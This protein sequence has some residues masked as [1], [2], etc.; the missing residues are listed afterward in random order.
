MI[1]LYR[2][3]LRLYPASF[4]REY[5]DE[6]IALFVERDAAVGAWGRVGLLLEAV[7]EEVPHAVAVHFEVLRQ[8]LRFAARSLTRA[9]AFALTAVLVT[10]IGVGANTAAFSVADFVLLR[11]LPYPEPG[12]LVRLCEGPREGGGWGCMNQLS[13]A[14]Y[15]DFKA[16]S[17]S[18][19]VL[20]A[21]YRNAANLVGGGEPQR[22][23]IAAVTPEVL[24]LLGVSPRF[25]RVFGPDTELEEP[26][27]V[28]SHGLWRSRFGGDPDAVGRTVEL[29]GAPFRVI[30]VMP[31][32]FHF[33]SRDVQVW[34]PLAFTAE[35]YEDRTNTYVEGVGR[36]MAGV[37]FEQARAD[38]AAVAARL[39]EAYP[40]TNEE[41]G[42]SFFRLRDEMS[43]R[44]RVLLL[45]LCGASLC[46]LLLTCANLASLL[47]ARAAGRERELAVRASLGAGRERLVRQ[48][49]T[50][51]FVLTLAGG[52]AGV[53]VAAAAVP[54]LT[55]LVPG[56]LPIAGRPGL[57]LRALGIG[58]AFTLVTG[59][60]IGVV[61]ALRAGG[62]WGWDALREGGRAGGGRKQRL[63]AWLVGLEVAVSVA[64]LISA[65]LL[66]RAV[67]QVQS[68]DPGFEPESVLTLKTALPRPEYD[69]PVRRSTFYDEVLSGVRALPGVESAAYT[70]G[71]PMVMTGGI[72]PATTPGHEDRPDWASLRFITPGYFATL[73]IPMLRGRD[74]EAADTGDRPFVAVVSRSFA[75]RHWP[76]DEPLGQTFDIAF[77]ARTVV[78]VVDD[79]R[80]RGLE[81]PSEPQVYLP[82]PQVP[83]GG[84]INYDPKDLV[85]RSAGDAMG[86]LPRIR[87]IVAAADPDQ[88]ISDVRMLEGVV[89][90]DTAAR[91]AQ[92]N[93]LAALAVIALLLAGVGI[94]GL[95]A[96]TV[97]QRSRE[98]AVRLALGAAPAGV[99]RLVLSDGLKLA[100]FGIVPGVLG[101][102]AAGRAMSSLLFGVEPAD[103]V[104]IAAV[105][106]LA[107]L[108]TVAGSLLPT[109][110]AVRLSP[111]TA[112]KA[113]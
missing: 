19:E 25:G 8:D 26:A 91:R 37:T 64:L 66:I 45:G 92:L 42:A 88:P 22:V 75:E 65:G 76:D 28:L 109:L 21:F 62:G 96:F 80:V 87:E 33:P 77:Q 100:L 93:V 108:M 110:R 59:L 49:L 104:T 34:T 111:A 1:R 4:R 31:P 105:V 11:P 46:L 74:V 68:V 51:S 94:H 10:A 27:V 23:A 103:P 52:V 53:V 32:D 20:G 101:A 78:G 70:T 95:L 44:Y 73:G 57:D 54:L 17:S 112:M 56:S 67:W 58:A 30:G 106:T 86:L 113:D 63:R 14:N 61:P 79:V 16:M 90:G 5:G 72:W 36:L 83:E 85:V 2:A 55:T 9:R 99:A 38:L 29:N 24:P 40:D 6:M 98:I 48:L 60:G 18:F 97:S 41:T 43:P 15:R 12:S 50:E 3:L 107:L 84:L 82:A 13:P 69:S 71:L 35:D 7:A 81:R 47:L 102:Y 39:A 89:A